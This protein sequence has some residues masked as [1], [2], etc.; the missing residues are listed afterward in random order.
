MYKYPV[1]ADHA[2]DTV[3]LV[4]FSVAPNR[5]RLPEK[6]IPPLALVT[7]TGMLTAVQEPLVTLAHICPPVQVSR[8]LMFTVPDV[9]QK[10]PEMFTTPGMVTALDSL[11]LTSPLLKFVIPE[12]EYVPVSVRVAPLMVPVPAPLNPPLSANVPDG[13]ASVAP[14]LALHDPPHGPPQTAALDPPEMFNV[15]TSA[16]TAPVLLKVPAVPETYTPL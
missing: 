2:A 13:N 15:P 11:K 5:N 14:E 1:L 4:L 3:A 8:P 10:P 16:F 12:T 7:P 9:V 6:L